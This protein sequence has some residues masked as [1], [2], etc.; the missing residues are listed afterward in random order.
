MRERLTG[1]NGL[2]CTEGS[3]GSPSRSTREHRTG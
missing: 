3:T 1:C 2:C